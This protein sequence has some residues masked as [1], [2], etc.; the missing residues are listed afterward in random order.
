M[1][2]LEQLY[3]RKDKELQ[4]QQELYDGETSHGQIPAA[5][6][7]WEETIKE[8]LSKQNCYSSP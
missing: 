6:A 4:Q 5:Q 2:E 3:R 1:K 7:K 8:M